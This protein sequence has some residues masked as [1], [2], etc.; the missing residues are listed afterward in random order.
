MTCILPPHTTKLSLPTNETKASDIGPSE[1]RATLTI[2]TIDTLMTTY[3]FPNIRGPD[4]LAQLKLLSQTD[5]ANIIH[6]E[7]IDFL[8]S[9][10]AESR[11]TPHSRKGQVGLP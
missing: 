6:I 11:P 5:C 7:P 8:S 9:G 10:V 2:Y 4:D 3:L 1:I